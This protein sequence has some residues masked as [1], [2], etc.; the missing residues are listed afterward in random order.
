MTWERVS[1][2]NWKVAG[3]SLIGQSVGPWTQQ[4]CEVSIDT[5]F[6]KKEKKH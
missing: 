2:W 3:S 1:I 6:T 5:W 4:L